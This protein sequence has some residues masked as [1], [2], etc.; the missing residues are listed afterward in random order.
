MNKGEGTDYSSYSNEELHEALSLIDRKKYPA[1]HQRLLS[2]IASRP[3]VTSAVNVSKLDAGLA[4]ST[5]VVTPSSAP[6]PRYGTFWPR[7]AARIVDGVICWPLI[8]ISNAV[9]TDKWG[10][11]PLLVWNGLLWSI[12]IAYSVYFVS[13]H[14]A[15]WGKMVAGV[16]VFDKSEQRYPS[17]QQAI[18]REIG[19]VTTSC[20]SLVCLAVLVLTNR[21]E[22]R[23]SF[24]AQLAV[25]LTLPLGIWFMIELVVLLRDA[26][27]RTVHDFIASTVVVRNASH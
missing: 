13:Q 24:N 2:E 17:I 22:G 27:S 15:T 3:N 20:I 5:E 26:K 4:E 10:A 16:Q 14:G 12:G 6:V 23:D 8:W 9:S 18:L 7:L 19:P 1:N 25:P 11:L 21:Y